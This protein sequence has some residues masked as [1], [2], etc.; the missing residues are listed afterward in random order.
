MWCAGA[1]SPLCPSCV[2]PH[3]TADSHLATLA[4]WRP[5]FL[6]LPLRLRDER[7][8][9]AR[10]FNWTLLI[11]QLKSRTFDEKQ[12]LNRTSI[13]LTDRTVSQDHGFSVEETTACGKARIQIPVRGL[14]SGTHGGMYEEMVSVWASDSF[15]LC[16]AHLLYSLVLSTTRFESVFVW[17]CLWCGFFCASVHF[18]ST[19]KSRLGSG[20]GESGYTQ[21]LSL[22]SDTHADQKIACVLERCLD[23]SLTHAHTYKN[24]HIRQNN[25]KIGSFED[26]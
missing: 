16:V 21:I 5:A 1:G 12:Q 25:S 26:H 4:W 8:R 9:G 6:H 14:L 17:V 13:F 11:S 15:S 19:E 2:S 20:S 24:M 7:K 3:H 10:Y 18:S 22:I 23:L